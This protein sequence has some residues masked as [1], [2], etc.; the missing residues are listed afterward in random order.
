MRLFEA[1]GD[2][3]L[4]TLTDEARAKRC[5]EAAVAAADPLESRHLALLEKLLERQDLA[6][7]HAGTARTAEL[8][9]SFAEDATAQA[10]RLIR[11]AENYLAAEDAKAARAAAE[12]A[13]EADPH[14]LDAAAIASE[15]AA[16]DGDHEAVAAMLGRA[17]SGRDAPGEVIAP[18]LS[19]LWSRLGDARLGRGDHKGAVNAL[20]K[21]VEIAPDADGAMAARRRLIG[22]WGADPDRRD[23]LLEYRR[24]LAGDS[25]ETSDIVEYARALCEAGIGDGGR[26]M[27]EVAALADHVLSDPDRAFLAAHQPR[28]MAE[29]E[30]YRAVLTAE[31]RAELIA[32]DED[33]PMAEILATLWDAAPLLWSESADALERCGV[34]GASRV[35]AGAATAAAAVFTR[36]ARALETP[37]TILYETTAPAAPDVQIV[38]VAPP[39]VVLGPRVQGVEDEPPGDLELRFLMGRAAEL[40][41]PERVIAAGLPA[42]DFAA[43]VAALARVF[44]DP[45]TAPEVSDPDQTE[46]DEVLKKTLPVKIRTRLGE[47]LAGAGARDLDPVRY[48]AACERAADRAGLLMCGDIA[49]AT[50][51]V[52]AR[53]GSERRARHLIEMALSAG[54]LPVRARLGVGVPA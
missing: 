28:R 12:R 39:V 19:L 5:Y 52:Q 23:Q 51:Q 20:E 30:A 21:A 1:L 48:R 3:A 4:L 27:L 41:R 34:V 36:A 38:C 32:D 17:L 8:M 50:G 49:T 47:L 54:Y 2:M 9:A 45:R 15:L 7:D 29:D 43:L 25:L 18:R 24:T 44:G 40:A 10:A 42:D 46:R 6:G 16:R 11:A 37:A 33:A 35:G 22:L 14:D 13:V 26:A 53:G 31:D